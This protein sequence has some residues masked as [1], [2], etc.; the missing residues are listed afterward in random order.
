M[1]NNR[2]K[3]TLEFD[4]TD[5]PMLMHALRIG[6]CTAMMC[7]HKDADQKMRAYEA[8]LKQFVPEA[9]KMFD[10]EVWASMGIALTTAKAFEVTL[11]RDRWERQSWY[12]PKGRLAVIVRE[13]IFQAGWDH[14]YAFDDPALRLLYDTLTEIAPLDCVGTIATAYPEKNESVDNPVSVP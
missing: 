9:A 8:I 2:L 4:V 11:I 1:T 6:A 14:K 10:E 13:K 12:A 5:A 7:G 3:R